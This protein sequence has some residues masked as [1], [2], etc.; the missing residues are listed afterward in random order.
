MVGSPLELLSFALNGSGTS[1][2]E[3]QAFR[4]Y[5][6]SINGN[7]REMDYNGTLS[8]WHDAESVFPC[9]HLCSQL[10]D[11]TT[12]QYLRMRST[13]PAWPFTP[14]WIMGNER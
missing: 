5:Y 4:L 14:I 1:P 10:T 2:A 12:G 7:I 11:S 13:T 9:T 3:D 6:Q 8:P